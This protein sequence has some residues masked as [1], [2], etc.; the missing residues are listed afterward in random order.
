MTAVKGPGVLKQGEQLRPQLPAP[1][2]RLG[3]DPDP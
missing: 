3:Q 2:P 1:P